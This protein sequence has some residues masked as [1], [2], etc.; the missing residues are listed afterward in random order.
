VKTHV[1]RQLAK[2]MTSCVILRLQ[3]FTLY[4]VTTAK[5]KQA[6]KEF[7]AGGVF[8]LHIRDK[9]KGYLKLDGIFFFFVQVW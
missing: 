3:D 6:P 5:R 8:D 4:R 7:I 9:L 1:L 2:L